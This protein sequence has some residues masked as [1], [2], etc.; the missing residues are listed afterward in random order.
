VGIFDPQHFNKLIKKQY[1]VSPSE[2][3]RKTQAV[4]Q[5]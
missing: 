3:R 4:I 2:L 1:G 5:S